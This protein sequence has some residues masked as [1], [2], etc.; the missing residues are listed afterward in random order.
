MG[1]L[2]S[3]V[4]PTFNRRDLLREAIESLWNQTLSPQ[5]YEIVVV[6]NAS[7]DGTAE[8]MAEGERQSPCSITYRRMEEN[9]GAANSRNVGASLAQGEIIAFTDSDCRVAPDW[10]ERGVQVFKSGNDVAFVSGQTFPKPDQPLTFFSIGNPLR[11]ENPTYPT[12]NMF[13]R[14]RSF[15]EAGGFDLSVD[16]GDLGKWPLECCDTEMA[17]RMKSQGLVGVYAADVIVY[18]EIMQVSPLNWL[19][20]HARVGMVPFLIQRYPG[21]RRK[22]LWWGPFAFAENIW[23]YLAV[24]GIGLAWITRG[25]SLLLTLPFVWRAA[26]V[27]TRKFSLQRIPIIAGRIVFFSLRHAV[28]C[29]CLIYGSVRARTLVL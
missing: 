13:Y 27:P 7:T 17:W 5:L 2:V 8:M 16:F 29:G 21:L 9:K 18:H 20:H 12:A 26:V 4:I 6:D 14:K 28:I 10:L 19:L 24:V 3:V 1:I 22:L 11:G 23:F 15:V 25:W